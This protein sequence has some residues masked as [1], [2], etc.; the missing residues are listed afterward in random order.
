MPEEE[1]VNTETVVAEEPKP[2][3]EEQSED[4][5]KATLEAALAG[6][7]EDDAE[8][9]TDLK[10]SLDDDGKV[11]ETPEIATEEKPKIAGEEN[12]EAE[13]LK[14]AGLGEFKT[15]AEFAESHKGLND[16][17]STQLEPL[18]WAQKNRPDLLGKFYTDLG[19]ALVGSKGLPEVESPLKGKTN[20]A[21]QETYTDAEIQQAEDFFN[22]MATRAGYVKG[23]D[24]DK[25]DEKREFK[26]HSD[27]AVKHTKTL[28]K[29]W[30]E[31]VEGV[32][33]NWD[34]D[35]MFPIA[36]N[37]ARHGIT[38]KTPQ[39]ITPENLADA[40]NS[41]MLA[42]PDAIPLLMES[43]KQAGI[44]ENQ[45]KIGKAKTLPSN[46]VRIQ[47]EP[48]TFEER[49]GKLPLEEQNKIIVELVRQHKSQ[50]VD[51]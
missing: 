15:L 2:G 37:L 3:A 36:Q 16:K 5:L 6:E 47:E 1:V 9:G 11:V 34:K 43:A 31:K 23:G 19:G 30:R 18:L 41:A 20:P 13:M 29:A 24:L 26:T 50:K 40:F 42:N 28:E 25:R 51:L 44:K 33:M 48:G 7:G 21:T 49:I 32:G 46:A 17:Y 4:Q 14:A 39:L 10:I 22:R 12:A 38:D 8:E 35:I 45:T 27:N